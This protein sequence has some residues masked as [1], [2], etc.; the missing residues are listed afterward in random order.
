MFKTFCFVFVFWGIYDENLCDNRV[1]VPLLSDM[2]A[3]LVANLDVTK[4][5][6]VI[7]NYVQAEVDRKI[8]E[9]V[10]SEIERLVNEKASELIKLFDSRVNSATMEITDSVDIAVTTAMEGK[11]VLSVYKVVRN[12][13]S[14]NH[15][16]VASHRLLR[17]YKCSQQYRKS[18][19][20]YPY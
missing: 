14:K 11:Y 2:K 12:T 15:D 18:Y 17:I 7:A 6:E 13:S 3:P 20:T 5:N 9:L 16:V 4:I 1:A 19:K 8:K 10:N